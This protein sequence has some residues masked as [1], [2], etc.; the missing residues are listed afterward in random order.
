MEKRRLNNMNEQFVRTAITLARMYGV[1]ETLQPWDYLENEDFICKIE[2]WTE[3]FLSLQDQDIIAFF[4]S[5]V[6]R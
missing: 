5:Q 1:A 4:E 3:Q 6:I 2:S